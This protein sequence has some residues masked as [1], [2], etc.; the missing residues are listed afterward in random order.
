MKK[1]ILV[2]AV[3]IVLICIGIFSYQYYSQKNAEVLRT[4][5]LESTYAQAETYFADADY[6]NALSLYEQIDS[7]INYKDTNKH[8]LTSQDMVRPVITVN[9]LAITNEEYQKNTKLYY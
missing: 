2:V 7:N 4:Q 1:I 6:K 5:K 8:K 9:D 3:L